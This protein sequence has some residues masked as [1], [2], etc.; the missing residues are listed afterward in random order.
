M[1]EMATRL[2]VELGTRVMVT[3]DEV[4]PPV[5]ALFVGMEPSRYLILRLPAS[6]GLN[7]HLYEGR[8][9][10]VKF[11]GSGKVFGFESGV[12]G[13]FI[14]KSMIITLLSYPMNIET[15]ELRSSER[16]ECYIPGKME[17]NGHTAKGFALDISPGGCKFGASDTDGPTLPE[18]ESGQL[19]NLYLQL[20]GLEGEQ[21]ITS[22]VKKVHPAGSS[23]SYGLQFEKMEPSIET[24]LNN[25]LQDIIQFMH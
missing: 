20:P 19:V 4:L 11:V 15:F 5:K 18:T 9:L 23:F 1:K 10:V 21:K 24:H 3:F 25:Y 14:K 22:I 17:I 6:T 7:D 12:I 2:N 16:I 8:K 13:Y